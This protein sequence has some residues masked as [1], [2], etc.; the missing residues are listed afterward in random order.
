MKLNLGISLLLP[1]Y[2]IEQTNILTLKNNQS[3]INSLQIMFTKNILSKKDIFNIKFIIKTIN[4]KFIYVHASYKLNIGGELIPTSND[5]YN[6]GFDIFI[7][8]IIY[9]IKINA[10]GI[11]IHMGKN[12][13]R[14]NDN[15]TV[16]NN[17]ITFVIKLFE[18]LKKNNILKKSKKKFIILFETPAGQGGEMCWDILD[19]VNFILSFKSTYFYEQIGVC[20]DTCHI[21][22]AGY[23]LNNIK[24][25]KKLHKILSQIKNK[26]KLIHLNDSFYEL[27]QRIDRHASIGNG[28]I[29]TNNLIKF[30][31]PYIELPLILETKPPYQ[32]QFDLLNKL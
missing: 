13:K 11:I 8:E 12:V 17:M 6:I 16:Y 24:I 29:N 26:I 32:I 1:E 7:K 21:Y 22:Q 3:E 15:D 23:D 25:I 14:K 5:L 20:L 2:S 31:L 18:K 28:F 9:A 4:F 19:F 27:G 10:D 30:I